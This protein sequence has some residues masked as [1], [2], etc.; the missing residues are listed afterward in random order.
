MT[1]AKGAAAKGATLLV[2]PGAS[3]KLLAAKALT[4]GRAA[5][6]GETLEQT[7]PRLPIS[8]LRPR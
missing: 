6:Q 7:F 5:D 3:R 4:K 1:H 8:L 2:R